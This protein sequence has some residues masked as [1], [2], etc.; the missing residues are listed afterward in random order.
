ML[1]V[2]RAQISQQRQNLDA[3]KRSLHELA[4]RLS[5]ANQQDR[6][7]TQ[8]Q[9]SMVFQSLLSE[10]QIDQLVSER[11]KQ[12]SQAALEGLHFELAN[13]QT[14]SLIYTG[15]EKNLDHW[16]LVSN[17]GANQHLSY[18]Q[19][20]WNYIDSECSVEDY[21]RTQN[22]DL[23]KLIA[24]LQYRATPWVAVNRA[25]QMPAEKRL[26]VLGTET[27]TDFFSEPLEEINV[28]ATGDKT[29]LVLLYTI[30]RINVMNLEQA[31]AWEDAYNQAI[32]RGE[33]HHVMPEVDPNHQPRK[34]R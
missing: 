8:N 5:A 19:P 18:C 28:V 14:L 11:V 12:T 33:N 32:A 34:E 3:M 20:F 10:E 26:L 6:Q 1:N 4:R 7:R 17:I 24:D 25:K 22:I 13:D 16:Q 30:H 23:Q 15:Q 29:Q 27:G 9:T 2:L 31:P 21:L